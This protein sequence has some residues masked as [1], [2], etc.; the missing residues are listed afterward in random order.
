MMPRQTSLSLLVPAALALLLSVAISLPAVAQQ[1]GSSA[2]DNPNV[3]TE[4]AIRH[5][6]RGNTY[7]NLERF[8]DALEEYRLSVAAHPEF[9]D[10]YR[11]MGNILYHL[12]RFEE[13]IPMYRN[14]IELYDGP[15]DTALR[16]ALTRV[17]DLL[18]ERENYER[19][20]DYDLQSVQADRDNRSL[21][22]L[23]AND[24]L[25][26][27]HPDKALQVYEKAVELNPG[28]AFMHRTLGRMY[29]E[30]DLLEEA[31]IHYRQAA[32]LDRSS[33]FY[34]ELIR[35]TEERIEWQQARSQ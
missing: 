7:N 27:G 5:Y 16:S 20:I 28:D 15:P 17:S 14:F 1:G 23:V 35:D 32:E 8:E 13:A 4:L 9:L 21:V 6:R 30:Q 34:R 25:N 3:D 33:D 12:E 11:N 22:F 18:R 2:N 24:Y 26:A 19:A 29:D 10:S 31:L